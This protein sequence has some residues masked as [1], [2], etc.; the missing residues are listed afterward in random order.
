MFGVNCEVQMIT[1]VGKEGRDSSSS[2]GHIVVS[3]LGEWK[4]FVPIVL[5]I[6][7]VDSDILF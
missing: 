3:E 6:I 2:T 4:E 5:L 7:A 1:L